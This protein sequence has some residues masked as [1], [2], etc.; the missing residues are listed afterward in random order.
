MEQARA[1]KGFSLEH[2]AGSIAWSLDTWIELSNHPGVV[3]YVYSTCMYEGSRRR[4][5]QA[6]L[7]NK[8]K[9]G[10]E[11][12]K[13]CKRG[14][15]CDRTGLPHLK[16]RPVT[17]GNRVVQF[18]TGD[19]REYPSGFCKAY[20]KGVHNSREVRSFVEVFSG[21]NAPLSEAVAEA[22]GSKVPGA[23]KDTQGKGAAALWL[24]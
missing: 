21:P 6:I 9:I 12:S 2:P 14:K 20:A 22:M 11:L 16:W 17:S 3:R 10:K 23:R 1:G 5:M 24:N 4:K 8:E 7:T 19:E 15:V 18:Q 13:V